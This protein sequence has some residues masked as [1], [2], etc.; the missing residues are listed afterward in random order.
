MNRN[1]KVFFFL[2]SCRLLPGLFFCF[3]NGWSTGVNLRLVKSE[4]VELDLG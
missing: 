2:I 3:K 1:G 4:S